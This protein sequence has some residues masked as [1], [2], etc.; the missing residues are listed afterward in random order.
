MEDEEID[1]SAMPETEISLEDEEIVVVPEG[2]LAA[3]VPPKS[4]AAYVPN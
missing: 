1:L 4:S 3:Y 2:D